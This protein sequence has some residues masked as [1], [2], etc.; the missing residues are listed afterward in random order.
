MR[1]RINAGY[2]IPSS[3]D[4]RGFSVYGGGYGTSGVVHP[5]CFFEFIGAL[6]Y[7][8]TQNWVFACDFLYIHGNKTTFGGYPGV[9]STG[10]VAT[11]GK[12]SN[13]QF[14]IAPAIEYNFNADFG[15]IGGIWATF[16]G[17]NAKA[18]FAPI[19]EFDFRF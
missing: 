19:L 10:S 11:V 12:S 7:Q 4:V 3:V 13:E 6:E 18:F 1:W 15:V 8:L 16:A 2:S 9:T 14:S 17:R 5:G